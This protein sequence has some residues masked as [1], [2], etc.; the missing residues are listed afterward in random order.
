MV[1]PHKHLGDQ[2]PYDVAGQYIRNKKGLHNSMRRNGWHLPS[3]N[4]PII[5]MDWRCGVRN[6]RIWCPKRGSLNAAVACYS[7]PSKEVLYEK[8][9]DALGTHIRKHGTS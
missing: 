2:I 4:S 3:Y 6:L 9:Y 5:T 7:K 8:V 1:E